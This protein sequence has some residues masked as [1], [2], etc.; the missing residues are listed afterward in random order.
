MTRGRDSE[1]QSERRCIVTGEIDDPAQLIRFALDGEGRITPDLAG[2]LPG[3]GYW[4]TASH[5]AIDTAVQKRLFIKA[6]QR[7]YGAHAGKTGPGKTE[8]GKTGG[9]ALPIAAKVTVDEDLSQRVS[10]LL[11]KN[12]LDLLGLARRVGLVILGFESVK[13]AL[14]EDPNA[15]LVTAADGSADGRSK[16]IRPGRRVVAVFGREELSLAL[17]RENVVHAALTP[18]GLGL[19]FLEEVDRLA[20]F[21]QLPE[22]LSS[23]GRMRDAAIG[24]G[25]AEN[26]VSSGS[27]GSGQ[28]A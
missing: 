28:D 2:K 6:V 4:V 15:V 26:T 21:R 10:A 8:P 13:A 12:C 14:T 20:G 16:L 5:A 19:R 9:G 23:D 24:R 7:A 25:E 17:G 1:R 22:W 18:Q 27:D 11:A 3:R